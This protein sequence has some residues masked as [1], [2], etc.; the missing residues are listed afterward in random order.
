MMPKT[1]LPSVT[2]AD[3]SLLPFVSSSVSSLQNPREFSCIAVY[4][5]FT[6]STLGFR[7]LPFSL[8]WKDI[9]HFE[10]LLVNQN[11]WQA[12]DSCL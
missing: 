11:R 5:Y 7:D 6:C 9:V 4:V 8:E 2:A 10:V 3:G 12:C 1:T